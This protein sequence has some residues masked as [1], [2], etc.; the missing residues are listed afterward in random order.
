M[1]FYVKDGIEYVSVTTAIN[2][3]GFGPNMTCVDPAARRYSLQRGRV[4]HTACE[5]I[6]LDV[7]DYASVDPKI[8]G[9]VRSYEK[10]LAHCDI[11]VIAVEKEML[12]KRLMV[13]CK[14]D[15]VCFLNGTRTV[16]ERKTGSASNAYA[17]LQTAGQLLVWNDLHPS[18][19]VYARFGLELKG[20]GGFARLIPHKDPEDILAF[21]EILRYVQAEER[22]AFWRLKYGLVRQVEEVNSR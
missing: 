2:L 13:G 5:F 18:E 12:S 16:L 4:V 19:Q 14:P 6:D 9:Y 17:R 21:Q 1:R 10:M 22:L 20:D 8:E 3:A 11:K 7:L 15:L